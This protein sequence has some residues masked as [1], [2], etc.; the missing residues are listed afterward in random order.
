MASNT[1][2]AIRSLLLK[3]W[4]ER[5]SDIQWG[6]HLKEVL[7]R[8]SEPKFRIPLGENQELSV[9]VKFMFYEKA[10]FDDSTIFIIICQ[11][12]TGRFCQICVAFSENM[13]SNL[14]N[15][16]FMFSEQS[17]GFGFLN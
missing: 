7:P 6:I 16:K 10:I 9:F 4:R 8:H 12:K 11:G 17:L 15:I 14:P 3:G 13:N 1:T 2:L 5:W